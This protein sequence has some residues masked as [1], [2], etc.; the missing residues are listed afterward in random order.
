METP[1]IELMRMAKRSLKGNWGLAAGTFFVYIL[2]ISGIRFIPIVGSLALLIVGGPFALGIV[3]FSLSI[4]RDQKAEFDQL[5]QGFANFKKALGTYLLMV[6]FVL[7]WMLLLFVPGIIAAISYSMTFYIL[8]D[9]PSIGAMEAIKKSKEM[10]YGHKWKFFC[11]GLRFIGWI[12]LC[13]LTIGIGIFW[14][15]PYMQVSAAKFYED[16]KGDW[17]RENV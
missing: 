17:G 16:V 2:I 4:A 11:L 3:I 15:A 5:F 7:L 6:L 1:N 12:L 10:M 13:C 9:D 8:A 14:L